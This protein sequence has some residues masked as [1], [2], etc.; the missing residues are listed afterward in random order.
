M[1]EQCPVL[2]GLLQWAIAL[3]LQRIS[4]MHD[5][6]LAILL[7]ISQY[8]SLISILKALLVNYFSG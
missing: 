7:S 8:C 3:S 5:Y 2:N 4:K 6:A 1:A